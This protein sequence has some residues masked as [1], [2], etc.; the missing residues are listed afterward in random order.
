MPDVISNLEA[1]RDRHHTVVDARGAATDLCW[2]CQYATWPCPDY[3][4]ATASL[5]ILTACTRA[6]RDTASGKEWFLLVPIDAPADDRPAAAQS[7]E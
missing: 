6:W 1:I 7:P 2:E 4:R 3:E 5:E